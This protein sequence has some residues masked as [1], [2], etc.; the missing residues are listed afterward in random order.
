[1]RESGAMLKFINEF[2]S[3]ITAY[4][5]GR[6]AAIAFIDSCGGSANRERRW[7]CFEQLLTAAGPDWVS[8]SR[9]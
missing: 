2:R 4:T 8:G 7:H 1:M 5:T 9:P 6:Q 3:Y